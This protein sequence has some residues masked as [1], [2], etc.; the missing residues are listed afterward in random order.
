MGE[1]E[2][3]VEKTQQQQFADDGSEGNL[4]TLQ[5]SRDKSVGNLTEIPCEE[6]DERPE[7]KKMKMKTEEEW[8]ALRGPRKEK[9]KNVVSIPP[10]I[11]PPE[12]SPRKR[13][14][15]AAMKAPTTTRMPPHLQAAMKVYNKIGTG[16]WGK[17]PQLGT[18]RFVE[19]S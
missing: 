9:M 7:K 4:D 17:R 6:P 5:R 12:D 11:P 10:P 15:E 3:E 18:G 19:Q 14:R 2:T 13:Q 8:A 16:K 1:K